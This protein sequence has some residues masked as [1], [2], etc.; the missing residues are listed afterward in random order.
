MKKILMGV[1]GLLLL[2]L[3]GCSAVLDA[4]S[5]CYIPPMAIEYSKTDATSFLPYTTLWDSERVML[6][7]GWEWEKAKLK[8]GF[9]KKITLTSQD[10]ARKFQV[11]VISPAI[12]AVFGS[13]TLALGWLGMSKPD[14]KKKLIENEAKNGK[15]KK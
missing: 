9:I 7:M 4:I 3:L 14:D 8:H 6:R 15:G 5:P 2:T 1:V 13:S 10:V 11:N 12:T